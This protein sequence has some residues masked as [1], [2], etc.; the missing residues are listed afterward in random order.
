MVC[1]IHDT[2]SVVGAASKFGTEALQI[3]TTVKLARAYGLFL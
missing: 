1:Y 2:S 3:A